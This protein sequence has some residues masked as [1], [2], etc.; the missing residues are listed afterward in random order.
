MNSR[1]RVINAIERRPIDR[2]PRHEDFW[3]TSM[4]HH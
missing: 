4:G 3:D 1:E 2:I